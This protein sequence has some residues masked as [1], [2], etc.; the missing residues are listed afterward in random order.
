MLAR[1]LHTTF[2]YFVND[3]CRSKK[4][5][6][7]FL[8]I[9]KLFVEKIIKQRNSDKFHAANAELHEKERI[10]HECKFNSQWLTAPLKFGGKGLDLKSIKDILDHL[11]L[12]TLE[13]YIKQDLDI[14]RKRLNQK[15]TQN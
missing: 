9:E 11:D 6:H 10:S 2:N 4:L 15:S 3:D 7:V 1:H 13:G 8:T 14:L 5:I 12:K